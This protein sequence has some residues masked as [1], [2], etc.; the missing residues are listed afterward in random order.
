MTDEQFALRNTVLREETIPA[1]LDLLVINRASETCIKI[2]GRKRSVDY[3]IVHDKDKEI[4]IQVRGRYHGDLPVFYYH[5]IEAA[6]NLSCQNLPEQYLNARLY[7]AE[8]D[9]LCAFLDLRKEKD[10]NNGYY[11]W[12]TVREY[13]ERNGYSVSKAIKDSKHNGQY[14]YTITPKDTNLGESL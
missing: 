1:N 8:R 4:Q 13:L 3:M 6:N 11:K 14:Y 5:D 9:E 7:A 10:P 12:P 2:D